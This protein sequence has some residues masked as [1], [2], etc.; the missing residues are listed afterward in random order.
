MYKVIIAKNVRQGVL[1]L[2]KRYQ[3]ALVSIIKELGSDP[4]LGKPL[5]R[6]LAGKYS[7]KVGVYRLIYKLDRKDKIVY[8]ITVGHRSTVYL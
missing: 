4:L 3:T 7:I 5:T 1:L 6:E 8:I 2:K